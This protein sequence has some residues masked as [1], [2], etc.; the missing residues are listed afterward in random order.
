MEKA[1]PP[2]GIEV[3]ILCEPVVHRAATAVVQPK[4]TIKM[5]ADGQVVKAKS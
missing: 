2:V 4:V 3:K 5:H 1:D